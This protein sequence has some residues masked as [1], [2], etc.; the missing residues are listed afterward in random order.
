[1]G[2]CPSPYILFCL[3]TKKYAKKVKTSPALLEKLAF[4]KLKLSKLIKVRRPLC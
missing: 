1:M 4:G 2:L 3:D